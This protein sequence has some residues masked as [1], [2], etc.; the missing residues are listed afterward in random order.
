MRAAAVALV[1]ALSACGGGAYLGAPLP[2]A[3]ERTLGACEYALHLRAWADRG[4][5]PD[6]ALHAYVSRI[7]NRIA[8]VSTLARTPPVVIAGEGSAAVIGD[9][10]VFGREQLVRL[11][12]EAE[13]A[14]VLAH[15]IVHIEGGH[16]G[17]NRSIAVDD[18]TMRELEG[19]ADERAVML[20]ERAGYPGS[21]MVR[22]LER[23]RDDPFDARHPRREE[24][25][26]RL[27]LLVDPR[28]RADDGRARFLTAIAGGPVG[29]DLGGRVGDAFVFP[30]AGLTVPMPAVEHSD[31]GSDFLVGYADG[32]DE[33]YA[34][35]ALGPQ[36]AAELVARLSERRVL[37]LSIGD[38]VV[39][40]APGPAPDGS[41]LVRL[42]ET[43]RRELWHLYEPSE[44][45]VI[46]RARE[47]VLLVVDGGDARSAIEGWAKRVRAPTADERSRVRSPRIVLV[48]AP[49]AGT[50]GELASTCIDPA[51]A[52]DL[53]DPARR[54]EAGDAIKCTDRVSATGGAAR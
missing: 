19:S 36:A 52:R 18:A 43:M 53:D 6:P 11:G 37:H 27:A 13:L 23:L 12:S 5:A 45:A 22:A 24:R 49:R 1:S 50:V 26:R 3:C 29:L 14:A 42:V 7:A 35:Y 31:V 28:D 10:I 47:A 32:Y 9:T 51:A 20:L 41:S 38:V 34:T 16:A 40:R 33:R 44:V 25:L 2:S 48:P 46:A 30:R 54:L 4:P 17:L 39:G 21:A 15:E 8:R